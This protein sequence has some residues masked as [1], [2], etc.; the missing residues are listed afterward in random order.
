MYFSLLRLLASEIAMMLVHILTE[1]SFDV[2]DIK[3]RF[4]KKK[5]FLSNDKVMPNTIGEPMLLNNNL[6]F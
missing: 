5:L 4:S 2:L 1:M 6:V 3:L